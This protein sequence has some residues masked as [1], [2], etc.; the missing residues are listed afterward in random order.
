MMKKHPLD[1][2]RQI[3]ERIVVRGDLILQT[4]THFGNGD[5]DSLTDMPLLLDEVDGTA[6]LPGTSIAGALRNYLREREYGYNA[7]FDREN[8]RESLTVRLFG[9]SR[10]D[11]EG[12][13]SALIVEDAHGAQ[14]AIELRDGVA[15]D[16]A[17][18]TA[19]EH[20]KFDLEL[21]QAGTRFELR[22]E[23]LAP[24]EGGQEL[25]RA[26]AIALDGLASGEIGMG[27]RKRRGYGRCT[28]EKWTV[29]RYDL[30]QH[31]GLMAWLRGEPGDATSEPPASIATKLGVSVEGIPDNRQQF[32]LKADFALDGS[33]LVRSGFGQSDQGPDMIHLHTRQPDGSKHPVLP[34]TSLAGALRARC[35]RIA[36]TLAGDIDTVGEP[37]RTLIDG[38]FGPEIKPGMKPNPKCASRLLV[39]E[40]VIEG[41]T[42][43]V[44]N[45]V[46]IDRFTGGAAAAKLFNQQPLFGN[47]ETRLEIDLVLRRATRQKDSDFEAE[48]G[49]LLL[50]LKD[51]WT[52][53]LTVGGEASVGRG[54]LSGRSA[55]LSYGD[56]TWELNQM[57]DETLQFTGD[58]KTALQEYVNA[59]SGRIKG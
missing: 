36:R 24:K 33:L 4:P 40:S 5:T 55:T 32:A 51:L 39:S 29:A 49:L 19:A 26:L 47:G 31:R 34:G 38:M 54:R 9:A 16:P 23:L 17:T 37:V 43:L 20:K 57:G 52:G 53:D 58:E 35:L 59:L 48:M 45:R 41:G 8:E 44:Q 42:S 25:K 46:S 15:I 30:T 28:V 13:Q 11:D 27:L 12:E 1:T 22:F 10:G 21:L 56:K 3:T 14:P 2:S 7:P 50:A 6:L 18:R